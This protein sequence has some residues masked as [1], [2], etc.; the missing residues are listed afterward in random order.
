MGDWGWVSVCLWFFKTG[1][2]FVALAEI[3]LS[4]GI[5]DAYHHN[6]AENR[7]IFNSFFFRWWRIFGV[8]W[9]SLSS[10]HLYLLIY[11]KQA[12]IYMWVRGQLLEVGSLVCI[13]QSCYLFPLNS[14]PLFCFILWIA[15]Y[16]TDSVLWNLDHWSPVTQIIHMLVYLICRYLKISFA[17]GCGST[18]L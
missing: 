12:G 7:W 1:F 10:N 2:V 18:S 15:L 5:K 13:L 4:V 11:L 17:A 16:L 6:L 3:H 9:T 8:H 14:T